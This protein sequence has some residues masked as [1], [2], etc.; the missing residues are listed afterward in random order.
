MKTFFLYFVIFSMIQCYVKI[1]IK[2]YP[3]KIFNITNPSNIMHNIIIQRLYA[4]LEIGNPRQKIQIPIEFNTN[5]FYLS[6]SKET[7]PSIIDTTFNITYFKNEDSNSLKHVEDEEIYY[8]VNFLVGS[9]EKDFFYFGDKKAE[10][11]FYLVTHLTQPMSGEVGIQINPS[12]D[13]NTAFEN[14]E[15]SFLRIL[16]KSGLI[17]NYAWAI[18]FNNNSPNNANN[19]EIDGYLYIGE[20]LHNIDKMDKKYIDNSM[21]SINAYLY[22]NVVKT[23]FLMTKMI[24]YR[25]NNPN[26]IINEIQL[27]RN[28][29]KVRLD[30]NFWGIQGSELIHQYLKDKLFTKENNCYEDFYNDNDKYSFYYC[31][32]N[33]KTLKNLKE[34]FPTIQFT[35]QDFNYNFTINGSDLFIEKGNYI[36]C[37]MV[38]ASYYRYDWRL[39][40]VFLNKYTFTTDQ[41]SKKIY[42]Y[43]VIE[44]INIRGMKKGT[45]VVIII[46]LILI[47]LCLGFILARKIYRIHIKRHANV[48]EDTF[49]YMPPVLES[50]NKKEIEMSPKLYSD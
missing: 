7:S 46:F 3:T 41:D 37:L 16:K 22:Q 21:N 17:K 5:D 24:I 34:N 28:Y 30:Y 18:V 29:L 39:G 14:P 15:K 8:G 1:P 50:K 48:L 40:K 12:S 36:Y 32:N 42:F 10:L 20:Y 9:R 31:D 13:L 44:D 43:S 6:K 47:C 38:F 23:E 35:H 4:T 33:P 2:Y 19:Q 27:S 11:D 26:D 45:L 25:K 49:E